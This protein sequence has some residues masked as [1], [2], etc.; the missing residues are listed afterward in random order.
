MRIAALLAQ[1]RLDVDLLR[2][3]LAFPLAPRSAPVLPRV[4]E[5]LLFL[6]PQHPKSTA[7]AVLF[8]PPLT[9]GG[10]NDIIFI[11]ALLKGEYVS[12]KRS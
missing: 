2:L 4:M 9:K 6:L 12:T 11:N 5:Q 3:R 10:H 7:S 1:K 8:Y